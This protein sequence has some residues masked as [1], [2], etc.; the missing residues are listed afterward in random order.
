MKT[1]YNNIKRSYSSPEINIISLDNE[2]SLVLSSS[3]ELPSDPE[4][5]EYIIEQE[6]F[7]NTP[8]E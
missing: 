4:Q 5:N 1:Q 6:H 7:E 2:I 8:F 3:R